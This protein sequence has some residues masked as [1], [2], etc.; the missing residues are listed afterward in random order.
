VIFY[1]ARTPLVNEQTLVFQIAP[2]NV[3]EVPISLA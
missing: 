2:D 3:D 1:Q